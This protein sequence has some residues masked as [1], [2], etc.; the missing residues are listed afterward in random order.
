[1]YWAKR[2]GSLVLEK[3]N[4]KQ[5]NSNLF[6]IRRADGILFSSSFILFLLINVFEEMVVNFFYINLVYIFSKKQNNPKKIKIYF[7]FIL[8]NNKNSK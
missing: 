7:L 1:M 5:K 4:T 3:K 6:L 8:K 2:N